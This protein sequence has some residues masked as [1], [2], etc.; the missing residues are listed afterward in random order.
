MFDSIVKMINDMCRRWKQIQTL[1]KEN[2]TRSKPLNKS[3]K[4]HSDKIWQMQI[5]LSVRKPI[6]RLK[7]KGNL[8]FFLVK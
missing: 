6:Y 3:Q 4:L 8:N 1:I 7:G 5:Y 2:I